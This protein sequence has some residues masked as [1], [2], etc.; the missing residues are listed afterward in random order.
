MQSIETSEEDSPSYNADDDLVQS[1]TS[2]MD[3][4][5]ILEYSGSI[6]DIKAAAADA[7]KE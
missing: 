5:E 7:T 1:D 4:G 2:E 3:S 6:S